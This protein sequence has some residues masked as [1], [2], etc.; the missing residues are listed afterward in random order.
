MIELMVYEGENDGMYNQRHVGIDAPIFF[1]N[2]L[3]VGNGLSMR[4]RMGAMYQEWY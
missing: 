1:R 2:P 4:C 3:M